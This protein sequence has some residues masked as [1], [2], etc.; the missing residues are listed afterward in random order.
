M[1]SNLGWCYLGGQQVTPT[2]NSRAAIDMNDFAGELQRLM[3]AQGLGVRELARQVPC[4]PGYISNLR[5]A[6]A[7]DARPAG[8]PGVSAW[9]RQRQ[10]PW[11]SQSG[12]RPPFPAAIR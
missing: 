2:A 1:R 8:W 4:N 3:A 5:V 6:G 12:A 7:A 9:P 11:C 10:Q